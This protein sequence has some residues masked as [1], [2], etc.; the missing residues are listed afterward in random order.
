MRKQLDS[1]RQQ[2][3]G[4]LYVV[5]TPIGNLKDITLRA[6]DTLESVDAILCEDTRITSRLLSSLSIKKPLILFHQH[7]PQVKINQLVKK[8]KSGGRIALVTDSGTPGISDPGSK[9]IKAVLEYGKIRMIPLPG[10]SAL[11]TALSISGAPSKNILFLGFLP[12][13]KGRQTL[14][15]EMKTELGKE[16]T[17][18]FFE[19]PHRIFKTL[20]SLKKMKL[21]FRIVIARELTKKFEEV[22]YGS[23][24]DIDIRNIKA[25]GEFTIVI[26]P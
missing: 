24:T 12:H 19:S 18:V 3:S 6:I 22:F 17:V 25:K 8:I 26:Y 16:R 11:T 10:P 20:S 7:T 1:N 13:K 23:L 15:K 9:L 5:A 14:F 4:R 2:E 21:P